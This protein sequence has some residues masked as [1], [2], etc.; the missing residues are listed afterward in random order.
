MSAA[1]PLML[2]LLTT[3]IGANTGPTGAGAASVAALGW[4]G[5]AGWAAELGAGAL[6]GATVCAEV[7]CASGEAYDQKPSTP[8]ATTAIAT[9]P[10]TARRGVRR[11]P[12]VAPSR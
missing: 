6:L 10:S 7:S 2:V 12:A 5:W 9:R 11:G 1:R 4:A 3:V 8:T